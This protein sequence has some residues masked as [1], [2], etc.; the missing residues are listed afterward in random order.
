[1]PKSPAEIRITTGTIIAGQDYAAGETLPFATES[2]LP[3]NLRGLIATGDEEFYSHSE[4]L[5]YGQQPGPEPGGPVVFQQTGG[6]A[7]WRQ[8]RQVAGSLQEQV[9][10]EEQA[11]ADAVLPPETEAALADIH[12]KASALGKAQLQYNQDLTDSIYE[13][14]ARTSEPQKFY[15]KRG[16]VYTSV[17]KVKLR[18]SENISRTEAQQRM[19]VHRHSR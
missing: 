5:I 4:R 2:E 3:P 16:A 10:A 17:E 14:A 13:E 7:Q 15:V 1:M 19:G 8:A 11:R 9:W 6:G 12:D 18:P